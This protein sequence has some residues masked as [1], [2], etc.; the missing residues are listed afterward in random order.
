MANK[1]LNNPEEREKAL[2]KNKIAANAKKVGKHLMFPTAFYE[3]KLDMD[4]L[5]VVRDRVLK[6][7]DE[8]KK[9]D[10]DSIIWVSNDNL[11]IH[12]D[13]AYLNGY[14]NFVA[15]TILQDHMIDADHNSVYTTGLWANISKK[16]YQHQSHN[17]PNSWYSAILY[18]DAPE[19][20]GSTIFDDPRIQRQIIQPDYYQMTAENAYQFVSKAEPGKLIFFPSYI[21]H[22][23]TAGLQDDGERISLAAN[24]QFKAQAQRI[25]Q[26]WKW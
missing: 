22:S 10:P 20:S 15:G 1:N 23:V 17:H 24:F 7:R 12:K 2:A 18:L 5:K 6:M 14:L 4:T 19:G 11:H 25:T 13:F 16:W 21:K 8:D 26:K 3:M 9:R